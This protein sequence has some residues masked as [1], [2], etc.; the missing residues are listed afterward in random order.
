MNIENCY[1]CKH[2][3]ITCHINWVQDFHF[4]TPI[5]FWL[6]TG[7]NTGSYIIKSPSLSNQRMHSFHDLGLS[8]FYNIKAI[9]RIIADY[10][11]INHICKNK[12]SCLHVN[13]KTSAKSS[14]SSNLS[15]GRSTGISFIFV[16]YQLSFT[17]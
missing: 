12:K 10:F 11:A 6:N 13:K 7:K 1:F 3:H 5:F 17:S 8:Y 14:R 15:L 9:S 2:C 4:I 16:L